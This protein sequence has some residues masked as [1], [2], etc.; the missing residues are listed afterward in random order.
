M[1]KYV[2]TDESKAFIDIVEEATR[3]GRR[4][5]YHELEIAEAREASL[6]TAKKFGGSYEFIGN[7]K[8]I[9]VPVPH[10]QDGIEVRIYQPHGCQ[11]NPPV[12]IYFHG[13]GGCV[14]SRDTVDTV[15][16]SISSQGKFV[17]ANVEYRLGPEHPYPAYIHDATSVTKWIMQ[18]KV[19][20]GGGEQSI[21]GVGGDSHGGNVATTVC[22]E[23]KGLDYQVL[24]FPSVD[25]SFSY[26]SH[27]E[28]STGYLL[29]SVTCEWFMDRLCTTP[30]HRFETFGSCIRR[31]DSSFI[32][33]PPCFLLITECDLLRDEGLAYGEKLKA[34]GVF[35]ETLFLKGTVHAFFH[36]PDFF[37]K[38]CKISYDKIVEF[39]QS[40]AAKTTS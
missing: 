15:C 30:A 40:Q 38:T 7:I 25:L 26:P 28:L 4:K 35:V 12:W 19:E 14:G 37:K 32:G 31:E 20:I 11:D 23:V 36:L 27:K 2:L 24:I 6:Q 8:N 10:L 16:R 18:N 21:V 34:A 22:H 33:Q 29:E 5:P 3:T 13:G 9:N 17:V 39:I 1:T